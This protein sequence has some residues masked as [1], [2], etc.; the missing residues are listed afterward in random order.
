M[1]KQE[2]DRILE[3]LGDALSWVESVEPGPGTL[4]YYY[5][6]GTASEKKSLYDQA[7]DYFQRAA[8]IDPDNELIRAKVETR[9]KAPLISQGSALLQLEVDDKVQYQVLVKLGHDEIHEIFRVSEVPSG[10]IRIAKTLLPIFSGQAKVKDL[11]V[12][13]AHEQSAMENRNIAQVLDVA[14]SGGHYYHIME[15]F[16]NS[17]EEVLQERTNL[18]LTEAISLA[19]A[20]LNALAYAH[21]HRGNDDVLRKIFHLALNPRRVVLSDSVNKAKIV[22]LGLISQLNGML[23]VTTSYQDLTPYELAYMAPEM[24]ER[25]P[26][27]MPDKL[28]QAA[29]LYSFG[30]VFYRVITGKVPFEGPLPEDFKKQHNEQYPVPPRVFLSSIPAKL[31]E[32]ILKCLNKDPKKRW[33]TPTELD[34]TLEKI[35]L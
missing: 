22:D 27:R 2:Y 15:D 10:N 20:L 35:H 23:N 14:E 19:R 12:K 3:L 8:D 16:Q 31:D 34:L 18:P 29:D 13:W 1:E 30:L 33:R 26:A 6:F 28:K 4:E 25:S 21:S 17:L 11:I 24:F 7:Q 5:L 32:A 9:S